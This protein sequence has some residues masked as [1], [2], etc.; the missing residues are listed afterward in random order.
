MFTL[1]VIGVV[2]EFSLSVV[3]FDALIIGAILLNALLNFSVLIRRMHDI[4]TSGETVLKWITSVVGILVIL[5][6]C[7]IDSDYGSNNYGE[8]PKRKR[9]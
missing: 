7:F 6:K 3:Q 2:D 5:I 8:N 4:N 1:L 9:K